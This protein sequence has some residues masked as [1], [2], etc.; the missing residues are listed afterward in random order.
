MPWVVITN[1]FLALFVIWIT[2]WQLVSRKQTE[3]DL[4]EKEQELRRVSRMS[5]MGLMTSALAHEINQPLTAIGSYVQAARRTLK[6]ADADTPADVYEI[7][8]KAVAQ[9]VRAADI[10]Q[11]L[12]H[13]IEKTESEL[14]EVDLNA[15]I[16]EA[17]SLAIVDAPAKGIRIRHDLTQGLP[18]VLIDK[19]QVQQVIVNLVRNAIEALT[20]VPER[21]LTIATKRGESNM[22]E[23]IVSDTG[24]GLA[25][26]IRD[27]LF[28]PF[29]TSKPDGMGVGLSICKAIIDEHSGEL[30][31]T[32]D[33]DGR[34]SFHFT[35]PEVTRRDAKDD[36]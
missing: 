8:D 19:V 9:N 12:R 36:R 10:V 21:V 11:R 13:A 29:V 1:R 16:S 28:T 32:S 3:R 7:L 6:R 20:E 23:V 22:V 24:P 27:R 5:D 26:E 14:A 18:P 33:P 31:V 35:L 2:A 4:R 34:T 25:D 30:W 17:S 15:F